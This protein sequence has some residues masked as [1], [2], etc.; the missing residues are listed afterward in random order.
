MPNTSYPGLPI[1]GTP[2]PLG[3]KALGADWNAA[4]NTQPLRLLTE[5]GVLVT[6]WVDSTNRLRIKATTAPTS[7]TDGTV[8]GTQT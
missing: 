3:A 4:V 7:D 5:A 8:V 6:L 1:P 2:G